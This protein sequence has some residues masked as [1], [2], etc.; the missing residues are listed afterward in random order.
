MLFGINNC[1]SCFAPKVAPKGKKP[2]CASCFAASFVTISSW[3]VIGK[4]LL[5]IP[6]DFAIQQIGAL[7][8]ARSTP[9][10]MHEDGFGDTPPACKL[11]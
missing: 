7:A 10:Y 9:F 3:G 4:V 8:E 6:G 5:A 11:R 1:T 2:A